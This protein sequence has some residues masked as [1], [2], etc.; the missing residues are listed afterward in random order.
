MSLPLVTRPMLPSERNMVIA[1]WKQDLA[2]PGGTRAWGNGLTTPEFWAIVDHVIEKIS[3][4]SCEFTMVCH[5]YVR[6]TPMAWAA[7]RDRQILHMYARTELR[8]DT[9]LAAVVQKF[10][11]ESLRP[12][13][14]VDF[15]PIMELKR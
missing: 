9:E 2:N 1:N 3:Y 5:E 4:P 14:P 15:N 7:T 10:M 13:E 12:R 8:K 11:L 6:E